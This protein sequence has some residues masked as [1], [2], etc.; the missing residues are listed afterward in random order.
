MI[1]HNP[2]RTERLYNRRA[3]SGITHEISSMTDRVIER[4][5]LRQAAR[6]LRAVRNSRYAH[7]LA[8]RARSRRTA[9]HVKGA[10][11]CGHAT[12]DRQIAQPSEMMR[13]RMQSR[14]ILAR[15]RPTVREKAPRRKSSNC[16]WRVL[17]PLADS[18]LGSHHRVMQ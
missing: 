14:L 16:D 18:M 12:R 9:P 11:R 2:L 13:G 15:L 7:G 4:L 5:K 6:A 10:A 3:G 17:S 8:G 1:R